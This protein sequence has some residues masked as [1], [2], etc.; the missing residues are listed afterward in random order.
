[1]RH[2][3]A[4]CTAAA[5]ALVEPPNYCRAERTGRAYNVPRVEIHASRRSFASTMVAARA[6]HRLDDAAHISTRPRAH[7]AL[8]AMAQVDKGSVVSGRCHRGP[9]NRRLSVIPI[10]RSGGA[11]FGARGCHSSFFSGSG[12]GRARNLIH[13]NLFGADRHR[14][15]RV[16]TDG[17]TGTSDGDSTAA[18]DDSATTANDCPAADPAGRPAAAT[19]DCPAAATAE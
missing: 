10:R 3:N 19:G 4:P 2:V 7:V 17:N 13:A 16:A 15:K 6:G 11:G 8:R 14:A 1:M 9:R 18:A 12:G 5:T